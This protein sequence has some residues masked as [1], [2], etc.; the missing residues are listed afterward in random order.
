MNPFYY[1]DGNSRLDSRTADCDRVESSDTIINYRGFRSISDDQERDDDASFP[2]PPAP[3]S[4]TTSGKK[5]KRTRALVSSSWNERF[6]E[7]IRFRDEHDHCFVPHKY[8]ENPKLSQWVRKQ[9]HQRK[10]KERGLHHTLSDER[11]DLLTNAGFIWDSHRAQWME[12]YQCLEAFQMV[13]GHC[14][15][16]SGFTDSTLSNW[17]KNQRKQYRQRQAGV[18]TAMDD[19]R[20]ELLD[21]LGFNWNPRGLSRGG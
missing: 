7:L 21:S 15:V 1:A 18:P 6:R 19:E 10:R 4:M 11:Q 12:R 13:N 2:P 8:P 3:A 17:V 20:M 14:N 16:P 9:R 5:K